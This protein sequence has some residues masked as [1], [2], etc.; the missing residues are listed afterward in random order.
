MILEGK[1]KRCKNYVLNILAILLILNCLSN[2]FHASPWAPKDFTRQEG[3]TTIFDHPYLNGNLRLISNGSGLYDLKIEDADGGIYPLASSVDYYGQF[4]II[5]IT[6][7]Q[8][9]GYGFI[10]YGVMLPMAEPFEDYGEFSLIGVYIIPENSSGKKHYDFSDSSS[11]F[12]LDDDFKDGLKA[13]FEDIGG[14]DRITPFVYLTSSFY[15]ASAEKM[16][17]IKTICET[18]EMES[19]TKLTHED[20]RLMASDFT[21]LMNYSEKTIDES[22]HSPQKYLYLDEHFYLTD[23]GQAYDL[24]DYDYPSYPFWNFTDQAPDVYR[25]SEILP[26][27]ESSERHEGDLIKHYHL[28]FD[29]DGSLEHYYIYG[30]PSEF[31]YKNIQIYFQN[32]DDTEKKPVE[33][34]DLEGYIHEVRPDVVPQDE[35]YGILTAGKYLFVKISRDVGSKYTS[36]YLFG[37]K[38][39][40]PY[41]PNVSGQHN[42]FGLKSEGIYLGSDEQVGQ[43]AGNGLDTFYVFDEESKEF[44]IYDG[45]TQ[46]VESQEAPASDEKSS[47]IQTIKNFFSSIIRFIASLFN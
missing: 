22:V 28:D 45:T 13:K 37:V 8:K 25:P 44:I 39:G 30:H 36:D 34:H 16:I 11:I 40:L 31:G 42:F 1:M 5:S 9:N 6:Y 4:S 33:S 26:T 12:T 24:K 18:R 43:A 21:N 14:I 27:S 19:F 3:D 35:D 38:D 47:L 15:S 17:E 41:E 23:T 2:P 32:K 7:I 20:N 29:G 46:K 10:G